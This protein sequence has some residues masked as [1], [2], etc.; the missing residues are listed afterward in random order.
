VDCGHE[1][2]RRRVRARGTQMHGCV[3]VCAGLTV[4]QSSGGDAWLLDA[5]QSLP[6]GAADAGSMPL[7]D[8]GSTSRL[9][10]SGKGGAR[11]P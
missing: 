9:V 3:V 2:V 8:G 1:R 11:M 6:E 7:V 4:V 5:S 10:S